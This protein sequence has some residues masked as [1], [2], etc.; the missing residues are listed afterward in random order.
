MLAFV[1]LVSLL[2]S[3][4]AATPDWEGTSV[5]PAS[6]AAPAS[7]DGGS[8]S[9]DAVLQFLRQRGL[10]VPADAATPQPA[11]GAGRDAASDQVFT[12]L[13]LVGVRYRRGGN[14][15]DEGFDCSGFTRH[16]FETSLGLR[17]PRRAEEQASHASLQEIERDALRPG[18]LVFF[19]TLRRAFSHV[20]IY[21]GEGRFVHAPRSGARVRLE[22][23]REPYWSRRFD[24]AR[25]AAI[26]SAGTAL[27][28]PAGSPQR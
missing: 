4:A 26:A 2:P 17:L 8:A 12:A 16:V 5:V 11:A 22:D 24:G 3:P 13:N 25:R 20:G 23:M 27:A 10:V 14:N 15:A 1:P 6:H 18:D 19:N 28:E 7:V 21:V 9:G